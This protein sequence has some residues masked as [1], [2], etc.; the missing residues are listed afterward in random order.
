MP[1]G[2][3]WR[4]PLLVVDEY[5]DLFFVFVYH[6]FI[7]SKGTYLWKIN[8][9]SMRGAQTLPSFNAGRKYCNEEM[10]QFLPLRVIRG[11]TIDHPSVCLF[12]LL[13]VSKKIREGAY[14]LVYA[15]QVFSRVGSP[16]TSAIF[17]ARRSLL[18]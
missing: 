1:D 3:I 4:S 9:D 16:A 15:V 11:N 13:Q 17:S 12:L 18:D 7:V 2:R 8:S 10:V 14:C 5:Y 6:T